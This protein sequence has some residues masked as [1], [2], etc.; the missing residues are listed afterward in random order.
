[1]VLVFLAGMPLVAVPQ[2]A[3]CL[4]GL[5][6]GRVS[7]APVDTGLSPSRLAEGNGVGPLSNHNP[8]DKTLAED[9]I[10]PAR[11]PIS[12]TLTE[13]IEALKAEFVEAGVSYMVL[14]NIDSESPKYSFKID[15][16]VAEGSAY[17]KRFEVID[18]APEQA[19]RRALAELRQWRIAGRTPAGLD[20]P[21]VILR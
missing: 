18:D 17:T 21:T 8:I 14:E 15:L 1:M 3:N 6:L 5:F 16:P 11:E 4:E 9:V 13:T 20:R 2:V 7:E 12:N 19:M 10:R